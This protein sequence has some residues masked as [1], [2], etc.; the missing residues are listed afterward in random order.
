[1]SAQL[2][3]LAEVQAF[4]IA[5]GHVHKFFF[6][7]PPGY[8]TRRD[9]TTPDVAYLPVIEQIPEISLV[10]SSYGEITGNTTPVSTDL[11]LNNARQLGRNVVVKYYDM[12]ADSWGTL[13]E[14]PRALSSLW[15]DYALGGWHVEILCG[16]TGGSRDN[17]FTIVLAGVQNMP[18]LERSAIVLRLVD[19]AADFDTL[20]QVATYGGTGGLDGT[21]DMAGTTKERCFGHVLSLSPTYLGTIDGLPTYSVNGGQPIEGVVKWRDGYIDLTESL[22]S[23]PSTS[24]WYQD[25]STGIITLGSTSVYDP[26]CEVK[27]DKTGSTWRSTIATI[28]RH[29]ATTH[30]NI[31]T[32]PAE[33][34][35][36]AFTTFDAANAQ[37]VGL[38]LEAG[39]NTTLQ[40]CFDSLTESVL[41]Y[42]GM[43]EQGQIT[44]GKILPASGSPVV[45]LRKGPHHFGLQPIVDSS[46]KIPAKAALVKVGKNYAVADESALDTAISDDARVIA[47]SEWRECRSADDSD[48]IAAY[49]N[50]ARTVERETLLLSRSDGDA[51]AVELR[52]DAKVPRGLYEL[53]CTTVRPEVKRGDVIKVY[54]DLPGFES[55]KLV[56]V[57]GTEIRRRAKISVFT[58][59][60]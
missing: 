13:T 56:R 7:S 42:W 15:T 30:S 52:D 22:S 11:R 6:S 40:Q 8:M 33:I 43:N 31:L 20:L 25:K 16:P 14:T 41:G 19:R 9:D 32:D 27:G 55:G 48:I 12:T 58:V 23:P 35:T 21:A 5:S 34:D 24:Q 51:L 59:R 1:M 18:I 37:T 57:I 39:N 60:E 26:T 2:I 49:G 44:L 29:L 10:V 45:T 50:R 38:W 53:T 46:R 4:H 54:D 36:A 47:T 3:W 28:I 17:D